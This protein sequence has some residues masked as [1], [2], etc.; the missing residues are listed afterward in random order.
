M[1]PMAMAQKSMTVQTAWR[2]WLVG[3]GTPLGVMAN[4][5]DRG[6]MRCC[7]VWLTWALI[8]GYCVVASGRQYTLHLESIKVCTVIC[9]QPIV[10]SDRVEYG[11]DWSC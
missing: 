11:T 1:A 8:L 5:G 9:C 3:I 10:L 7:A 4:V 2:R 6:V